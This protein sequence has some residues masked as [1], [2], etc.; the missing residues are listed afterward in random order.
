AAKVGSREPNSG[1]D[2]GRSDLDRSNIDWSATDAALLAAADELLADHRLG[3]STLTQLSATH[4]TEQLIELTM[5]VGHYAMIAGLL[6]T[7]EVPT[8]GPLPGL[9][10]V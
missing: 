2:T 9:G 8:E 4:S 10:Q 7:F 5:L 3:Q 6:R 1:P